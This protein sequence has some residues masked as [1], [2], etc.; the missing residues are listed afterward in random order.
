MLDDTMDVLLSVCAGLG[1]TEACGFRVFVPL[2][3]AAVAAHTGY[4]HPSRGM[5]WLASWP[6]TVAFGT[7]T[8]VEQ[9]ESLHKVVVDGHRR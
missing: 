3:V 5:E 4:L 2:L 8:V 9:F 6:A 1:L 7:A